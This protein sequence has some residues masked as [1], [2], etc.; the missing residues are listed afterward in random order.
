MAIVFIAIFTPEPPASAGAFLACLAL[1]AMGFVLSM[2]TG[3]LIGLA[4]FWTLS[5]LVSSVVSAGADDPFRRGR[6]SD[7]VLP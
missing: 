2:L 5:E 4:A 7:L 1:G 6:G 3:I